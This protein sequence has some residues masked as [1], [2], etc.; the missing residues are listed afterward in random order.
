MG[1][2]CLQL[3]LL[4]G[5]SSG[6]SEWYL[7]SSDITV[8]LGS[9]NNPNN[10]LCIY[11][12]R[13]CL[14]GYYDGTGN[15]AGAIYSCPDGTLDDNNDP[16]ECRLASCPAITVQ[17]SRALS[18]YR[19]TQAFRAMIRVIITIQWVDDNNNPLESSF[20]IIVTTLMITLLRT[21][22]Q[23]QYSDVSGVSADTYENIT[24]TCDT[25]YSASTGVSFV[26]VCEPATGT[27]NNP[28]NPGNLYNNP[29]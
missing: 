2:F 15:G 16:L 21:D 12:Y 7:Q 14:P 4:E 20:T 24:V 28:N 17:L 26:T 23:V 9:S 13:Y 19:I 18:I 5:Y 3:G 22:I 6:L 10:N 11:I 8:I 25:G 1:G 27:P 29:V